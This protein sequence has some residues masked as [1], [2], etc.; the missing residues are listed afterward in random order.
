MGARPWG[1]GTAAFRRQVTAGL[2]LGILKWK[3]RGFEVEVLRKHISTEHLI[4]T[5]G[6]QKK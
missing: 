1:R 6:N 4:L 5:K 2:R 3:R